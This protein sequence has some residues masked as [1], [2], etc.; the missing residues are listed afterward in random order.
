MRAIRVIRGRYLPAE[1]Q[2]PCAWNSF[3]TVIGAAMTVLNALRPGL[4]EKLY[5]NALVIN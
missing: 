2:R 3:K 1:F 4:G 5:E